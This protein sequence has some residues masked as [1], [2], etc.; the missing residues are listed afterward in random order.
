MKSSNFSPLGR[1]ALLFA[2]S[3][4]YAAPAFGQIDIEK[5]PI[6][7]LRAKPDDAV[8]RLQQRLQ[9]KQTKLEREE[10]FGYLRSVLKELDVPESSQVLVFSKTSLQIKCI[11]PRSPRSIYFNDDVYV[12]WVQG[13]NIEVSAADPRLGANFYLFDQEELTR[14]QFSRQTFECL[15]CHGSMLTRG[16]PGHMVRSV[17]TAP[18]GHQVAGAGSFLTDHDS[19]F[20]ERWGGWYV[21]GEHGSM[22][23]LGNLYVR[24]SDDPK[25]LDLE[26]GANALDLQRWIEPST[27]LTG[28]SDIVALMVLEHQANLHNRLTRANMLAQTLEHEEEAA[29]RVANRP[30]DAR[31]DDFR[32]QIAEAATP[33]VEHLLFAGELR[34]T[35]PV[36]GTS[37]FAESFAKRGPLDRRGRSLRQF[38]L[39]TRLFR[40]P[41]SYLVYSESFGRLPKSVKEEVLRQMWDVLTSPQPTPKF[42]HLSSDDRLAIRE[43]L[44][45][46]LT[47]LP[48]YWH[49]APASSP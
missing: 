10:R 12:G 39:Q 25:R 45:E 32:R 2:L 28:H 43:I 38:D 35:A 5:P 47:D 23:H 40:Y 17:F 13:G 11:S 34:L 46:T 33:V 22:R 27:T 9:S 31:S 29:N 48:A 7:Y 8:S 16:V 36:R 26:P 24:R 15:Q 1:I 37:G 30:L 42:E 6:D 3:L 20:A 21:T 18:D 41:C 14:P 44:S 19:P 49:S 4:L